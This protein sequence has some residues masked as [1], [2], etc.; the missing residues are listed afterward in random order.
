MTGITFLALCGVGA[1][2]VMVVA[3]WRAVLRA[4]RRPGSPPVT[5]RIDELRRCAPPSLP[6]DTEPW[7]RDV[8]RYLGR[9]AAFAEYLADRDGAVEVREEHEHAS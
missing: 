6:R 3:V 8:E 5:G 4:L 1:G 9:H 2:L 7:I